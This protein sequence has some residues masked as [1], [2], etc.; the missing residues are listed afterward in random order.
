MCMCSNASKSSPGVV[1]GLSD[2]L[3]DAIAIVSTWLGTFAAYLPKILVALII[4]MGGAVLGSLARGALSRAL[5]DG[6][7]VDSERVARAGQLVI[8]GTSVLVAVQQLDIEV[9]FLTTL[10]T[11]AFGALLTAGALAFGFGGRAAVSNI[12]AGHYAR[13]L[14]E[15]GQV[16]R[17]AELKGR[18]VRMTPTAVVLE[19]GDGETAIPT[20]LFLETP[21]TRITQEAG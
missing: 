5:P 18:I 19:T 17:V 2:Q 7:V 9:G 1:P 20:R 12:L 3:G 10:L 21:S 13:E 16:I 14:Y 6:E 11:I 4:V 8:V 15:V